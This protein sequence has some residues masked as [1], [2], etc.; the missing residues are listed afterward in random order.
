MNKNKVY[1]AAGNGKIPFIAATDIARV[2]FH[3]LT[4]EKLP[5]ADYILLGP[6]LLTYDEVRTSSQLVH[7]VFVNT[8]ITQCLLTQQGCCAS[9]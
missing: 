7:L 4:T 9:N 3:F 5:N 1:S 2:A 6:E 8:N